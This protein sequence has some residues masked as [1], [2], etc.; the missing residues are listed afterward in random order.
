MK[1]VPSL[2]RLLQVTILFAVLACVA[3][4]SASALTFQDRTCDNSKPTCV[5][6]A[7]NVDVAYQFDMYARSGCPPYHYG[8]TG[9]TPPPGLT[10]STVNDSASG[11][12]GRLAGTPT[13]TGHYLFWVTITTPESPTCLGDRADRIFDITIGPAPLGIKTT[14]LRRGITGT[15][16]TETLSATGSGTQTWSASGLPAGLSLSGNQITG[17][18][19]TAG[20]YTV[21]ITVTDGTTT[22]SAQFT[23]QV[24]DPLKITAAARAAEVGKAFTS[25]FQ[26]TGGLGTYTWNATGAPDGL[27]FDA[28]SHVLSGTPTTAGVYTVTITVTDAAAGLSQPL[29]LQLKVAEHVAIATAKL[30]AATVGKA[31]ALKLKVTGGVKP[32]KWRS[33]GKLPAGLKLGATTGALTGR[34]T[35]AGKLKVTIR[36]TDALRA[37][38]TQTFTITVK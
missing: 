15:P 21:T 13:A 24:I 27:T 10:L 37:S 16:Y 38:F 33:L 29:E 23:L 2:K 32:L 3:A 6:P 8:I 1:G 14:S 35:K 31:Y 7:G 25:A 5:I 4:G 22:K 12:I 36:V 20:N 11:G 26:A 17:T 28:A 9:G 19:T 30:K 34:P 18:P